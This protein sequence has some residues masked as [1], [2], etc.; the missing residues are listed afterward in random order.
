VRQA[1]IR[2]RRSNA[3]YGLDP[4]RDSVRVSR[5]D[6]LDRI[7]EFFREPMV[8]FVLIMLGIAGLILEL[9]LPGTTFPGAIAAI[10]FVLFFWAYSF[11]GEFTLLAVLLFILGADPDRSRNLPDSRP[12]LQRRRRRGPDRDQPDARDRWSAGPKRPRTGCTLARPLLCS[13]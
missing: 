1:S 10:C 4:G 6:L 3:H 13:R 12:R 11:V 7:A 2:L 9:K 5:D 8:N